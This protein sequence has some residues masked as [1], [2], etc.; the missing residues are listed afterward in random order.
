MDTFDPT[1][2]LITLT[3]KAQEHFA[4]VATDNEALGIRLRLGGGGCAG[5]QYEWD[6]VKDMGDIKLQEF[7]LPFTEWTFWLDSASQQYL[8]GS[9]IDKKAGI[10]GEYID[11]SSPLASSACGCGESVSFTL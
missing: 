6:I 5:F 10:T 3:D 2:S 1:T 9:I 11:I 4:K 7:S 8:A